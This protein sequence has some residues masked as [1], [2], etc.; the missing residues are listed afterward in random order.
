MDI[1]IGGPSLDV[2]FDFH[3]CLFPFLEHSKVIVRPRLALSLDGF[4]LFRGGTDEDIHIGD[5]CFHVRL[6]F[7]TC[8]FLSRNF[9]MNCGERRRPPIQAKMECEIAGRGECF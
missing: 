3:G 1:P 2:C 9:E 8:V 5:P 6:D 4:G 7:H